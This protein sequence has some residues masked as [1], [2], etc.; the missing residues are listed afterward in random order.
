MDKY[1]LMRKCISFDSDIALVTGAQ[2]VENPK[3]S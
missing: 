1:I 2:V 3:F